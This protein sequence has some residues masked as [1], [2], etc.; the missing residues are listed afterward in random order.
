LIAPAPH[1]TCAF[2]HLRRLAPAPFGTCALRDACAS[3]I[4]GL[5]TAGSFYHSDG[6]VFYDVHDPEHTV[7]IELAK[8]ADA[9]A[10][11]TSVIASNDS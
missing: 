3:Q 2:W 11:L 5:A 7:V 9:V 8:A 6:F 4:P 10:M 1:G